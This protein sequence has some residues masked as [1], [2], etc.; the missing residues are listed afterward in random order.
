MTRNKYFIYLEYNIELYRRRL[1]G[2]DEGA[3]AE[4]GFALSLAANIYLSFELV[5]NGEDLILSLL[6]QLW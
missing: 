3:V 1:M 2:S 5:R 4:C 6:G